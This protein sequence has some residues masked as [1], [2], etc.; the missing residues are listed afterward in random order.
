MKRKAL[1][2]GI[3]RYPFLKESSSSEGDHLTMSYIDADEVAR[4]L[5]LY[6]DFEV[7]LLPSREDRRKIIPNELI[8]SEELK[9]EITELFNPQENIPKTA[10]LYF[11]GRGLPGGLLATSDTKKDN[12]FSV[13]L[14]WL[15]E[16]LLKSPVQQQIV[17]LDCRYS[18]E[19]LK[20]RD[21]E[22]VTKNCDRFFITATQNSEPIYAITNQGGILTNAIVNSLN[23]IYQEDGIVTSL[24]IIDIIKNKLEKEDIPQNPGFYNSKSPII[25][26][27]IKGT[28]WYNQHRLERLWD[29]TANWFAVDNKQVIMNHSSQPIINDFFGNS[30]NPEKANLYKENVE[31]ILNCKLPSE[32][33]NNE[34]SIKNLH[35]SLK[36]LCG[37]TFCGESGDRPITIGSAY[38]I[39]LIAYAEVFDNVNQ[40]TQ[41][42]D[43]SKFTNL[44]AQLLP[45]QKPEIAKLSAKALHDLFFCLFTA[46]KNGESGFKKI[47]FNPKDNKIELEFTRGGNEAKQDG[48]LSLAEDLYQVLNYDHVPT[49]RKLTNT[50]SAILRLWKYM[51]ISNHGFMSPGVI[52]M[53]KKTLVV[54]SLKSK[55]KIEKV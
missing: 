46:C 40:L 35:E 28:Q 41:G 31:N 17:W 13:S 24:N 27:G 37:T 55:L 7:K 25:I 9:Q 4:L 48:E 26:T 45:F 51:L 18:G 52:Y 19:L 20:F 50:K 14:Q 11:V 6:G 47:S 30:Q 29:E 53:E 43:L 54:A 23:P 15:R 36:S 3:N 38:L 12:K 33:W 44:D 39:A 8:K 32:W 49:P 16:L 22:I 1:V 10:L 21:N 42:I 34:Q 5:E 2:V